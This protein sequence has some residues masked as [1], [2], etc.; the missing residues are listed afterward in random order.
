MGRLLVLG[1]IFLTSTGFIYTMKPMNIE[2]TQRK[3]IGI[4]G[5]AGNVGTT[6]QKGLAEN[7]RLFLYDIREIKTSPPHTSAKIDCTNRENLKGAFDGLDALIHLAGNPN[8]GA[9]R[10]LTL[11]NNFLGTSYC[12]DEAMRAGVKKIVFASSNFYHQGDISAFL[13]GETKQLITLDRHP[14]PLSLY[15]ESKVYGENLGRHLSYLGMQF[16]ALRIGWTVPEDNPAS[17]GGNYMRAVFC[18]KRDLVLAFTKALEVNTEFLAAFAVS[19]NSNG[20]FDLTE[21]KKLLGFV[22]QDNAENYF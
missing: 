17:V 10:H 19:N 3:K 16:V 9:P 22:P 12:F 21:T 8:P 18:S 20:V 2:P 7:Y 4:T 13:N 15:G 11:R 14:T 1:K 6:L 5:A